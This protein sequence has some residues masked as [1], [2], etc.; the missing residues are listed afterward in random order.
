MLL[1]VK[2][3]ASTYVYKLIEQRLDAVRLVEN[4]S[5]NGCARPSQSRNYNIF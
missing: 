1:L 3:D 5:N 4:R 2:R